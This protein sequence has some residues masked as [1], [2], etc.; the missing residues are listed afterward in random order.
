MQMK[1]QKTMKMEK[2]N[3]LAEVRKRK[4]KLS[5]EISACEDRILGIVTRP[6]WFLGDNPTQRIKRAVGFAST[7]MS[8]YSF[9]KK[10]NSKKIHL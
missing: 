4:K 8:V 5:K 6:L 3:S 2:F 9:V 1:I 10:I 7:A